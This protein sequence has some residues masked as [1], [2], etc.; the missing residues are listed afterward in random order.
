MIDVDPEFAYVLPLVVRLN[1]LCQVAEDLH[2]LEEVV[3]NFFLTSFPLCRV[4]KT[5]MHI[6]ACKN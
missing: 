2:P 5:K 4:I 1:E 6:C 3:M